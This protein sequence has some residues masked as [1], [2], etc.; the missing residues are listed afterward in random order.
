MLKERLG[1]RAFVLDLLNKDLQEKFLLHPKTMLEQLNAAPSATEWFVID[2]VQKVPSIL[3]LVHQQIESTGRR[4]ALT[5]SSSR[6]IKHGGAK[7]LPGRACVFQRVPL[8]PRER[9][10]P[11]APV[12]RA[13]GSVRRT[14][15]ERY[16]SG[17]FS[18]R[19]P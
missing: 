4:F 6:K 15:A 9:G 17:G 7:L 11:R 19:Q 18:M 2:E 14:R 5:G 3:D 1:S 16:P 10:E 12:A 13:P 8:T